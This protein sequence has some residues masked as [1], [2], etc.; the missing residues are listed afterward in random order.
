MFTRILICACVQ[1]LVRRGHEYTHEFSRGGAQPHVSPAHER[2][3]RGGSVCVAVLV[4]VS[5]EH[6]L[7]VCVGRCLTDGGACWVNAEW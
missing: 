7:C 4:L 5:R 3:V 1:T 6:A 2:R